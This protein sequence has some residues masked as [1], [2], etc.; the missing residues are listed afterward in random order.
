MKALTNE[1]YQFQCPWMRSSI[2]QHVRHSLDH[3]RKPL[4]NSNDVVR[5]DFRDRNTDVENRVEAAKKALNEICERVETLDTDRLMRN[6]RVSF[7]LSA[8]GTECEIPST[9]GREMAFA[10]HHCI[11]HNATIKQIL[12]RN[13]P[14]CIDQLS[15]DF[16]T[17]P[18]TANFHKLNQKEA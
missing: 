6:M 10:V 18:S 12:L 15:S 8:D 16:G 11:H 17:A 13:F 2:G 1:Q 3:L 9:L 7:M 5:Y 14:S 4:E